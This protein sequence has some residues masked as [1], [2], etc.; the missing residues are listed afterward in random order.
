LTVAAPN[1]LRALRARTR[2]VHRELERRLP[3]LSTALDVDGYGQLLTRFALVQPPLE[4]AIE[5]V[6]ARHD[7]PAV[8][9]LDLPT[10]RKAP[11]LRH[12]LAVLGIE[13]PA[14]MACAVPI[15]SV[16]NAVGALY[17]TEGATLGGAVISAHVRQ[18]L[19]SGVPA[20]FFESYGAGV[21]AQWAAFRRAATSLLT[22]DDEVAAAADT[23]AATFDWFAAVLAP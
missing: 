22:S 19:G 8:A 15:R 4:S 17:V 16:A 2:T 14:A 3:L 21:P 9:D 12:D 11:A 6:L 18:S 1:A 7:H 23:A 20:A 5:D 10:R 13:V